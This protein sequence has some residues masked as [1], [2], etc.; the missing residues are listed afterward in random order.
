MRRIQ[1]FDR[2]PQSGQG[3]FKGHSSKVQISHAHMRPMRPLPMGKLRPLKR[4]PQFLIA[5]LQT[6]APVPLDSTRPRRYP[7]KVA[8]NKDAMDR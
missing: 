6:P 8:P 1:P 4:P 3:F 2:A 7:D 5:N